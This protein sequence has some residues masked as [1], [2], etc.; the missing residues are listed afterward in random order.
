MSVISPDALD[1][2]ESLS[3]VTGLNL[4][5]RSDAE[6][7][8]ELSSRDPMGRE[9]SK[10]CS[11]LEGLLRKDAIAASTLAALRE[12][13]NVAERYNE[14]LAEKNRIL[15]EL[16]SRDLLTGL[17]TRW[18]VRDK[19][20]QEL[21]RSRRHDFPVSVLMVDVDHFKEINDSF[22][23]L[24]GD[25]VL[26]EMGRLIRESLR[27]YDVPGRYGGEEFCLLL[28]STPLEHTVIVAERLREAIAGNRLRFPEGTV[29]VTASIGIAGV[30]SDPAFE[31]AEELIGLADTALYRA[32]SSGR[33]RVEIWGH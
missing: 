15:T 19:I 12:E 26:R 13:L 28:P 6:K 27:T 22:G 25:E 7:K 11:L 30:D 10:L 5:V 31:R 2:V 32:K 20:E 17:Y 18:F 3:R 21:Q 16:A 9:E 24:I 29:H 14:D 23:H 1:L 33:N 8:L 4:Q